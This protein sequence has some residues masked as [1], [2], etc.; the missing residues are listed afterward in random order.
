M[1]TEGEECNVWYKKVGLLYPEST[2]KEL[3]H[4]PPER[5]LIDW[6]KAMDEVCTA[7]SGVLKK[8]WPTTQWAHKVWAVRDQESAE[9]LDQ[10]LNRILA[11]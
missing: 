5:D 3:T 8:V 6:L 2:I 9:A 10:A 7:A 11:Y 1:K 4:C